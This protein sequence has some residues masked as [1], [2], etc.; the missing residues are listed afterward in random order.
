MSLNKQ[1]LFYEEVLPIWNKKE[2]TKQELKVGIISKDYE[3]LI[4]YFPTSR[5]E[6]PLGQVSGGEFMPMG[7]RVYQVEEKVIAITYEEHSRG[8]TLHHFEL[9]FL[10]FEGNMLLKKSIEPANFLVRTATHLFFLGYTKRYLD[11][12]Y[13]SPVLELH[14]FE[15]HS[16]AH[17]KIPI[18]PPA[19]LRSFYTNEYIRFISARWTI[20]PHQISV[21][22]NPWVCSP[23][24]KNEKIPSLD[25][26]Y[27]F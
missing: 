2:E 14:S 24:N 1:T 5:R 8:A 21:V 22:C 18:E 6:V 17:T 7:G 19:S 26:E 25:F 3:R 12:N 27:V 20:L 15:I 10:D 23:K 13:H 9:H 11:Q 4:L 16:L